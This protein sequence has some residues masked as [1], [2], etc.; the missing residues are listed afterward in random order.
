MSSISKVALQVTLIF[1]LVSIWAVCSG[2]KHKVM[3][4]L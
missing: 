4:S 2:W 1:M 3:F